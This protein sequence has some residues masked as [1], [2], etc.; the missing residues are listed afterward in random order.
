MDL[1]FLPYPALDLLDH[2]TYIPILTSRGCPL[3]CRYCASRQLQPV[4]RRRQPLAVVEELLYWQ[5]RL[6]LVDA[7]FY[8]DALLVGAARTTSW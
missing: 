2:P 1:D 8:D 7:A 5:D 3:E 4:Y 6:D